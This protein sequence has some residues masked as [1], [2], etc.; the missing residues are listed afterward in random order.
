MTA[1]SR[2]RHPRARFSPMS[3]E[4]LFPASSSQRAARSQAPS[5]SQEMQ[6]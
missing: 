5:A 2:A 4:I 6:E 1:I 3:G